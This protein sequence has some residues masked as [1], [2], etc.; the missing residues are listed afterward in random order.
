MSEGLTLR[1]GRALSAPERLAL[2]GVGVAAA[3]VVWPA[4][5]SATGAGLPCPLRTVTGIPCPMCGMT[6]A[7]VALVRGRLHDAVAAN[8]FVLL[9]AV[10]TV[11]MAVVL[12]LRLVGRLAPPR[13]WARS[14][15]TRVLRGAGVLAVVSE[16]WQLHRLGVG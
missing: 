1:P 4:F 13:P 3:A 11:V 2:L 16:A 7:S 12:A 14:S 8:P 6:T 5:E 9:L 15:T 10:G